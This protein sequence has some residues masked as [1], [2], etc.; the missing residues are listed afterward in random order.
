MVINMQVNYYNINGI[1]KF[2]LMGS[3]NFTESLR[4]SNY[5]VDYLG[6]DELDFTINLNKFDPNLENCSILEDNYYVKKNYL[7]CKKESYK[8]LKWEIEFNNLETPHIK[9]NLNI[10]SSLKLKVFYILLE[11]LLIDPLIHYCLSKKSS[12]LMHASCVDL[13]NSGLV[14]VARGGAGKT[15][16]STNLIKK[17]FNFVSDNYTILKDGKG[18]GFVEPLNIFTY[19]VNNIKNGLKKSKKLELL[20][21]NLIFKLSNGYIKVFTRIK[22]MDIFNDKIEKET[23]IKSIFL[24]IPKENLD[25]IMFSEISKRELVDHIYFNQKMEFPYFDRY[26]TYYSY[27]F[28]ENEVSEHWLKYK[29]GLYTN[30]NDGINFYRIDVPTRYNKKTFDDILKVVENER[31]PQL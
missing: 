14:F 12:C 8:A 27:L 11:G 18:I 7:Y 10:K 13:N 4:Y 1:V 30:L 21:K 19:N 17:G 26:I 29:N 3:K 2:A 28:S 23:E 5:L 20:A 6:E 9:V 15:S 24:I 25:K 31:S 22:P 16:I